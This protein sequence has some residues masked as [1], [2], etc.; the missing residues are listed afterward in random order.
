[1]EIPGLT[2]GLFLNLA[3]AVVASFGVEPDALMILKVGFELPFELGL[4]G[5]WRIARFGILCG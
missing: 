1:M 2:V 5:R 4:V 3:V